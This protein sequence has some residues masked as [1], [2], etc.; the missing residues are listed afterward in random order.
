M[1]A[2]PAVYRLLITAGD[3]SKMF[4][5]DDQLDVLLNG[6]RPPELRERDAQAAGV[7]DEPLEHR[8]PVAA[9]DHLRMHADD[10]HATVDVRVHVV[11]LALPDLEHLAGRGEADPRGLKLNW[12]C[13]QSSSSKHI[14]ISTRS[15]SRPRWSG[16]SRLTRSPIRGR[17][18][19]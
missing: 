17:Y 8:H 10:E 6:L 11:E 15:A 1:F 4:D 13:G 5:V 2:G 3:I 12:K 7:L 18:G 14:G 16:S 9:A 19:R